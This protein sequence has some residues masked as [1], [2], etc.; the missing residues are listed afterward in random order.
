M[1]GS[2]T[3]TE[4]TWILHRVCANGRDADNVASPQLGEPQ[5]AVILGNVRAKW[6][7]IPH[8]LKQQ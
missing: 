7:R 2:V 3:D 5:T 8:M 1:R 4:C 6:K